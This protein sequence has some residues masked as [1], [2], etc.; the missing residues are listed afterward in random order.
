MLGLIND[1]EE[2]GERPKSA[3]QVYAASLD[4]WWLQEEIITTPELSQCY[5]CAASGLWLKM[6]FT[7]SPSLVQIRREQDDVSLNPG[8]LGALTAQIECAVP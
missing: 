3:R 5:D 6:C 4:M 7:T 8:N 2:F 1:D